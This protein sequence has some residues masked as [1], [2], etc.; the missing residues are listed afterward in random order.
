[1]RGPLVGVGIGTPRIEWDSVLFGLG[2]AAVVVAVVDDLAGIEPGRESRRARPNSYSLTLTSSIDL[3]PK[4]RMSSRSASERV[5]S[6][7][8][9]AI[10]SRLRQLP[11]NAPTG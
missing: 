8:T 9:V 10:P 3:L 7:P 2:V 4:L 1:M 6:S 11:G 5:T